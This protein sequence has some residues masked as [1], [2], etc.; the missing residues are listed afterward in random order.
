MCTKRHSA[1]KFKI[2]SGLFALSAFNYAQAAPVLNSANGH[3]YELVNSALTFD[4]AKIAAESKIYN[5]VAGHLVTIT[6][7]TEQTFVQGLGLQ[8]WGLYWIGGKVVSTAKQWVTGETF[9]YANFAT[10]EPT[11]GDYGLSMGG[12]GYSNKWSGQ[13]T[14]TTLGDY[15]VEYDVKKAQTISF[16]P[17]LTGTVGTTANLSATASSGLTAITFAS[18]TPTICT[19]SGTTLSFAAVGTC[20]VTANQAGNA[21]YSAATE[22]SANIVVSNAPK[23][24]Q[25]IDLSISTTTGTVG[26]TA[27]LSAT[28]SSGL[29]VTLA[30]SPTTVCTISGNMLSFVGAGTCRITLNQAGNDKF[31][32][33]KEITV[34]IDVSTAPKTDQTISF[35]PALT[36]TVGTMANLSATASSGLTAITFASSPA[37]VCTI[38]GNMVSFV[39]AG[40]CIVTANQVGNDKF[41]AAKE[42]SAT[43]VVSNAPKTDQTISFSPALTGTVGT[44]A[45]LSAT[46]TSGLTA[47]TF[48][49]S[50]ATVCTISGN[51]VSFVSAGNCIV[52]A[53]QVG[54]DKF[55]AAKEVSATIVVSNAPKTDQTISFSPAL[56]GTVGTTA[57]LSA[58]ATSGLTAI[59]FAS[60]PATVCTISGNTVSFVSAGN[61]IVTANQVGND[62][63]NAAKE[64]SANITVAA[65]QIVKKDQKLSLT[66]EY[67]GVAGETGILKATSDSGLTGIN[68]TTSS[69][70]ICEISGSNI[71]YKAEGTCTVTMTQAG[72]EQF[73]AATQNVDIVVMSKGIFS[74]SITDK[75]KFPILQVIEGDVLNLE[76]T[77]KASTSDVGKK[78]KF[79]VTAATGN[80]VLM[81]TPQGFV[82]ATEPLQSVNAKDIYLLKDTTTLHLYSGVLPAGKY[83]VYAAYQ[84][85]NSK[86]EATSIFTVKKKQEIS[87]E[88]SPQTPK[89][90]GKYDLRVI[91]GGSNNPIYLTS[92]TVDICTVQ[93]RT[94]YFIAEGSCTIEANQAGNDLFADTLATKTITIK[95]DGVFSINITDKDGKSITEVANNEDAL[96]ISLTLRVLADDV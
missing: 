59:T 94:V 91:G 11:A 92:T 57:N 66:S 41:N 12:S 29:T 73:N 68:F 15:I 71:T 18:S 89:V 38:S 75:D 96:N 62:K 74:L 70:D 8:Q 67:T 61:C 52:T 72:N 81:L 45:N 5:G 65:A 14:S 87:F 49:S 4:N 3:Y 86:Q 80:T 60:S 19:I 17:A 48:A 93:K 6:D 58:T 33:A 13:T 77:F 40:N 10:N 27:E 53:N 24:D 47:I 39:G 42:V 82:P 22:V 21:T 55:N 23:T 34:M 90:G 35:S 32:A 43:I 28:A 79:Y 2:I 30:S 63:F 95:S 7:A 20:T 26:Q 83:T 85:T 69:K 1:I 54:N 46:A 88:N 36:G 76:L 64:V 51:T 31:N 78:A 16:S 84:T 37:T 56:T 9:S 25:M 50:P 44:T